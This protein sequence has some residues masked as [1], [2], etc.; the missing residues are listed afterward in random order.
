[1]KLTAIEKQIIIDALKN[2]MSILAPKNVNERLKQI[3]VKV[4]KL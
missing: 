4:E 1:M 2:G 3:I